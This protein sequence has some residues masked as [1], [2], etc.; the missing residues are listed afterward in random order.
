MNRI[1]LF[2]FFIGMAFLAS[3]QP[4]PAGKVDVFLNGNKLQN[5]WAGGLDLPQFS[6]IDINQDGK[7]DLAV[8]DKKSNKFLIFI[9][10]NLGNFKY[11]PQYEPIFPN[12]INNAFFRDYNCDGL[13]DIFAN[14]DGLPGFQ[15]Y[16]QEL[17]TNGIPF[18][19]LVNPL[20]TFPSGN[21]N[22]N[23]AKNNEDIAAIEDIDG[24]GDL[25]II[26]MDFAFGTTAVFY[27]NLSVENGYGCDS[28][29]FE[30]NTF[31]WG[32][33]RESF[34]DNSVELDYC[35]LGD[36]QPIFH[37]PDPRHVG[38]TFAAIDPDEDG[39][40]DLLIGDVD[41]N[42]ITYLKNGG[43]ADNA[44]MISQ[45][46]NFPSYN[47]PVNIPVFPAAFYVDVTGDGRKDLLF[48]PNSKT[49]HIN[50]NN[51][52]LY[53]NT[54]NAN[55]RFN[56]VQNDFLVNQMIDFGSFAH[57]V[58]FDHNADGLL[59]MIVGN[60]FKFMGVGNT[61]GSLYYFE[62]TGTAQR[63]EFTF[64]TD[65]YANVKNLGLEF[66]RPT[67]GDI[68]G[69]GDMDMIIGDING[70][71]HLFINTAGPGNPAVFN[72]NQ[73][74][75]K[76]IDVG[77]FCHPF[78]VDLNGDNLL[79][80]VIGRAESSGEIMYFQNTG[81]TTVPDFSSTPTNSALG[82]IQVNEPGWLLGFSSPFVT[83]PDLSGN[84]YIYSGSDVG[85]IYKYLINPDSLLSGSF[86]MI[87]D[88][89]L[90]VK[91]GIR[92]TI[93]VVDINNDGEND[94]FMGNARGGINFYS[95]VIT[96]SSIVFIDSTAVNDILE[97]TQLEFNMYP[98]PARNQ[99]VIETDGREGV[100]RVAIYDLLGKSLI[101]TSFTGNSKTIY[102]GN[103]PKGIY[104][105]NLTH[106][107]QSKHRKLILE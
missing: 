97:V 35:C 47:T 24:D 62:N 42:S 5:P 65:N 40:M 98:N 34:T 105:V 99:I 13:A 10:D 107:N 29:I 76:G 52:W 75:Y 90:L 45:D 74:Q 56:F 93:S 68:D 72:L 50:T 33:F 25:D 102:V 18:F 14:A 41:A 73:L 92:T 20:L 6:P 37:Q 58:F 106:K 39:R 51:V 100:F 17:D 57:A 4:Y 94:Y 1:Y 87:T 71:I 54:G 23:I 46:T 9:G 38:T 84:R 22:V 83:E 63:P 53:E 43:T 15:V 27:K 82:N 77:S 101:E 64:V 103:F 59:D 2:L 32:N 26:V 61:E 21:F 88:A 11:A 55:A 7:G 16:K 66:I 85:N 69:D 89:F 60:G 49:N 104:I 78:L 36:C 19:T 96:D 28:L 8:F 44:N 70:Y 67:F 91:S 48:A 95:D 12:V 3:A 31:C 80:L 79:D 81:T 30:E 86:E